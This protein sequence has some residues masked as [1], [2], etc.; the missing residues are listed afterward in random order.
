[1]NASASSAFNRV[2]NRVV[3][4]TSTL[5]DAE[6]ELAYLKQVRREI[7]KAQY[8]RRS[9]QLKNKI[10]DMSFDL[11]TA[12]HER[13]QLAIKN[14]T[15]FFTQLKA[16]FDA[17]E[18][19]VIPFGL[20][21]VSDVDVLDFV[22]KQKGR[23]TMKVADKHY[24]INDKVRKQLKGLVE[25]DL[26]DYDE[27]TASDAVISSTI[28]NTKKLEVSPIV[29]PANAYAFLEGAFFKWFNNTEFDL[30]RYAIF[31]NQEEA[32]YE[33]NCFIIALRNA[34]CPEDKI[35]Q[36]KMKVKNR[37]V[38]VSLLNEIAD[39]LQVNIQ[40]KTDDIK[41]NCRR[42]YGKKY[43]TTYYIGL[44]ESHYF[45]IEP[46][47]I[48]SY[49]LNN[50]NDIKDEKNCN[51]IFRL[52]GKYY[53][54]DDKHFIDSHDVVKCLLNNKDK[55]LTEITMEQ[56]FIATTQ[57]YDRVST[58]ITNLD[59]D[60]ESC[61]I[62]MEKKDSSEKIAYNNVFFDFETYNKDGVHIPY[63]C[64]T[65]DGKN[66]RAFFGERC[67]LK[68]LQSLKGNTRLIAHNATYDLRFI[69]QDLYQITELARGN[70]LI[71]LSAKFCEHDI[72][73]KDSYHLITMGL[74]KFPKVF[75]L[76]KMV[77]EVMPYDLYNDTTVSQ[78]YVKIDDALK[79]VAPEDKEQ[80][81]NNIKV[82]DLQK[83]D[84]YDIIEYSS[85]YCEL[86]CKI[87]HDGYYVFRGW[88]LNALQLDIDVVLTSASL[89]DKYFINTGC[90]DGVYQLGGVPQMY[91]QGT[92]VGGRTMCAENKKITVS[93]KINDFD[94]VSLYP[95]AMRRMDG[96]LKGMPKVIENLDYNWLKEQD[97]Y[98]VDVE[99]LSVGINRKFPLLSYK[100]DDG[101]R[102]FTNDMVG[103]VVRVD[104]Y[105][106][107][108]MIRFQNIGF[109]VIRGYY[110]NDGFNTQVNDT[111]LYLFNKR[112]EMKK[113][114]NP[115]EMVY[116]LIMNSGYG[117]SI[118]K[119][120]E[121]EAKFFDDDE[122]FMRFLDRHYN[123][124]TS[125]V[126]FGQKT[127]ANLV[128]PLIDHFNRAH[129]G[130]TILSISKRIMNEV[131]CLAEDNGLDMFYQDTDSIHI[132]DKDIKILADKFRA[133]Y[134][135][136]LIGK[137]LGQFHSDFEIDGAENV[138]ATRSI[139]LGKKC[140]ID[141][142]AGEKDGKT[143]V[144]YH[145]R[146]KGIP[147][148]V[149]QYH[150][151]KLGYNN[152]F[153]MYQDLYNGVEVVFDLTNDGSKANFKFNKDYTINTLS[154]FS[155]RIKF[156]G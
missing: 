73:V 29:K 126:K 135:R 132:K 78:K 15:K 47:E 147:N 69:I 127:K 97:G 38:P 131:M 115:A 41:N 19:F 40:I 142:L 34:G 48:T 128:K 100:N 107:E 49:C 130:T 91:I 6:Y 14:R 93:G 55:L 105:T 18:K 79:F 27:M 76:G 3:R 53:E 118:M 52:K 17:N 44:L 9:T 141:E 124:I 102:I 154:I 85:R 16:K 101:V 60:E 72:Q 22:S 33:D 89:A 95:S 94:A 64:R 120:V 146:M 119:P 56:A 62:A 143:V 20:P 65:Y 155:R 83:D 122:G 96:F 108:D 8:N 109:R 23:Y 123:W 37:N 51:K 24:V 140:Y 156:S 99:V 26:I 54:R 92:V 104:K 153:E 150:T 152:P 28:K 61:C 144:D 39:M 30:S 13:Q 136:E 7:S 77:K 145:I 125:F 87:L 148:K 67:A 121:T 80:F 88:I 25:S 138:Y 103:R 2:A 112:L 133:I 31:R 75:G 82:W 116:K 139:F 46:V 59:Y 134:G 84:T 149:I 137:N 42:V 70:R 106:L 32:N 114:G 4:L 68:M 11:D 45:V 1:M 86:D 63:L 5:E 36:V 110:F 151:K 12:R 43:D 71:S 113:Q 90:Y 129:I 50:Y 117:K 57:F 66:S 98:F 58:E 81:L 35:N 21:F 74:A 10:N 111:I